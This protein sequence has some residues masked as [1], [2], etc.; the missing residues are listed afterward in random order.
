M[1]N[2]TPNQIFPGITSDANGITILYT[3][4]GAL[5]QA[6][7]DPATGNASELLRAICESSSTALA[8][9]PNESR[10]TRFT[11][12]KNNLQTVAGLPDTVRQP[13]SASFDFS[14]DPATV[15][16]VSES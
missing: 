5:S 13:F 10:P 12:T 7:A 9:L 3:D 1:A 15:T 4:L 11:F 14:Y 2:V 16:S 6:E 8:A